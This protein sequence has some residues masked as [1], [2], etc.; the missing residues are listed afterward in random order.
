VDRVPIAF[1]SLKHTV[2]ESYVSSE[3][4]GVS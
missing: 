4:Q 1:L 2:H 3:V